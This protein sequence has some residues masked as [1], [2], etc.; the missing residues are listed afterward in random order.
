MHVLRFNYSLKMRRLFYFFL[1]VVALLAFFLPNGQKTP[2]PVL[3]GFGQ[4]INAHWWG[5]I[6]SEEQAKKRLNAES[7]RFKP[8][9]NVDFYGGMANGPLLK[10]TGRFRTE[11]YQGRWWFVTPQGHLFYS[12][13]VNMIL[14]GQATIVTGRESQFK[15]L[16][17]KNEP[18]ANFYSPHPFDHSLQMFDFYRANVELLYKTNGGPPAIDRWRNRTLQRLGF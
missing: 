9:Q 11:K 14:P 18:A 6:Q 8:A 5:K 13:G 16:P 4:N 2:P 12:I 10:A 15:K 7:A 3:D 17:A 1:C